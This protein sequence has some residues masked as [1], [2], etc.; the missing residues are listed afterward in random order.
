VTREDRLRRIRDK[1]NDAWDDPRP[2]R[3]AMEVFDRIEALREAET[4]S[5]KR[6][7]D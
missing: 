4:R 3:P 1:I 2:S 7:R 5:P 6:S